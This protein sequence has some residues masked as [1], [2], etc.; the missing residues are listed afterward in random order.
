MGASGRTAAPLTAQEPDGEAGPAASAREVPDDD[1]SFWSTLAG[2]GA[3][4]RRVIVG[5]WALHPFEPQFPEVEWT[6][7]VG[8]GAG[9]FFGA[10][11]QNS[12]DERSFIAGIERYWARGAWWRAEFGVGYR[13]GLVTGYDERLVSWAEHTPILPFAGVVGWLDLGPLA[14]DIYY[15]YRA[16]TLETSV[17]F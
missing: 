9:Q 10:T 13:L 6:R 11:L 12:Y 16:I 8:F 17:L 3:D 2:T 14:V 4:R 5:V 15:V 7:G 1:R